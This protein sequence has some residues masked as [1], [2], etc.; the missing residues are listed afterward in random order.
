MPQP[1]S[2]RSQS[3]HQFLNLK[4]NKERELQ[5]IV[6]LASAMCN[7]PVALISLIDDDTQYFKFKVGTDIEQN[8]RK[9]SFCQ[10]LVDQDDLLVI[11]D[12]E[13]DIRFGDIP[14]V[15]NNVKVRFYAGAP[16]I[17]NDGHSMGSLCIWDVKPRKLNKNQ[18]KLL[19]MLAKRIIQI[20]E[21]EFVV[22]VLKKQRQ[23]AQE[24]EIRLRSFFESS[25]SCH[26]L[27]GK[28][29]EI[30]A[31]NKAMADFVERMY[32][33]K[34]FIGLK[35]NK[36]LKDNQ[37]E[38]FLK[39]YRKVL[40]GSS[41]SFEQEYKYK[42]EE[43]IWMSVN[44]DAG[45]NPE[46]KVIGISYNATD[47][48]ERKLNE[49]HIAKQNAALRRIAQIQSHEFRRPVASILGLMEIFKMNNYQTNEDEVKM[50]QKA[51]EELDH[52]IKTIVAE[53]H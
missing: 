49:Q 3:V 23:E 41:V 32:Q 8:D 12:T 20:M 22:G 39:D 35:L 47:I 29:L 40:N 30:L 7:T 10:Y 33:V 16:L 51:T 19:V 1:A 21:F 24:A 36:I 34:L 50:M 15:V 43:V 2:K 28:K 38:T 17:T 46:G 31:Y 37:L 44:F 4:L 48:T 52:K 27:V 5:E 25:G 45:Y 13:L 14:I 11:H 26:L 18:K 9:N 53:T 6:E 42:G